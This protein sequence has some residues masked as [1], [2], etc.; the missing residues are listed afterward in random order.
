MSI[1]DY[2]PGY[3]QERQNLQARANMPQSDLWRNFAGRALMTGLMGARAPG[4]GMAA[5]LEAG[6][7]QYA[8]TIS[9]RGPRENSSYPMSNIV[10][11]YNVAYPRTGSRSHFGPANEN[12]SQMQDINSI[13]R[14]LQGP[15]TP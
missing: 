12:T 13:I 8:P 6:P 7:A 5:R 2:L 11:N 14:S 9:G 1:L 4:F 10:P 3:S 15:T